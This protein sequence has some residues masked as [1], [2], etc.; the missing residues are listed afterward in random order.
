MKSIKQ[1]TNIGGKNG[2]IIL[3]NAAPKRLS[4]NQFTYGWHLRKNGKITVC[5]GIVDLIEGEKQ[6]TG[7]GKLTLL[8]KWLRRG[9]DKIRED[10]QHNTHSF[11]Y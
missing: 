8:D 4:A 2:K 5:R 9:N 6:N 7:E 1:S 10:L 11:L 3:I